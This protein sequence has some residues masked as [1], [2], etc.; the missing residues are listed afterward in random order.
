MSLLMF[1]FILGKMAHGTGGQ[2]TFSRQEFQCQAP[3]ELSEFRHH[4]EQG[5]G[6][7]A[8]RWNI[9]S[10]D[11][12]ADLR[13]RLVQVSVETV[14]PSAALAMLPQTPDSFQIQMRAMTLE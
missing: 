12:A 2:F 13:L 9:T 3:M 7:R 4:L 14:S 8:I 5:F 10:L 1:I 6:H 11:P